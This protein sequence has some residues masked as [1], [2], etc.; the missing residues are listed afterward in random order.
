ME[1]VAVAAIADNLAIG[2]HGEL[3]WKS[4]PE[5]KRQYRG[6]IADAPVI[7]GRRTFES[8][9]DDLPGRMQIV[10]S[11]ESPTYNEASVRV[12]ED[13]ESAIEVAE[14]TGA[15]VAYVIGGAS[16]YELFLPHIDR[17][18]LSRVPGEYEAD[19]FFPAW[20][21]ADWRLVSTEEHDRFTIEHWERR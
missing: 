15:D 19:T 14:R 8:M 6:R 10:L 18:V 17:M 20:D 7:L 2:L 12:V 11:N 21:E 1:L 3:P 16:I 13:V 4:I 5:D 9:R